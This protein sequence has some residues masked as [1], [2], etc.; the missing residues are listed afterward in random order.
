[1]GDGGAPELTF[2]DFGEP[3]KIEPSPEVL[4]YLARRRSSSAQTL[5]APGPSR[6]QVA[7]LI[8]LASR[9]PDHGKLTPWR[10]VVIEAAAKPALTT[11]FEA[12]ADRR[13]DAETA[14]A[15]L[16]KLAA[17]PVSIAVT[18]K[19]QPGT[20]IP[21][22]E[23]ELSAAAVC[24]TLLTAAGA[25]GFGASWITDWYA[26]EPEARAILG[27]EPD[28]RIAGFVHI[29]TPAEPPLERVRPDSEAL[30]RYWAG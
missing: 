16:G 17:S 14:R 19:I 29:G 18:S 22:W 30:T 1:M 12:L 15:K 27:L 5:G 21:D 3:L 2:A 7:L 6:E 13:E 23:Q 4:R 25:M 10:F 24:M 26:Y 28:E 11:K 20:K 8:R 9:A